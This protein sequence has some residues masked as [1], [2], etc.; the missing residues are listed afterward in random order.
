MADDRIFYFNLNDAG[1]SANVR[2][3]HKSVSTIE[4]TMLHTV[5]VGDKKKAV[6]CNGEGCKICSEK[7]DT[8]YKRVFIHLFDYT[9]NTEKVWSRTDKI[10][11]QLE[12][13]ENN[14]GDLSDCVLNIKRIQKEFPKYE[15]STLNP[16]QFEQ[17]DASLIDKSIAYRFYMTRSNDDI[18]K[19]Y[20]TGEFPPKIKQDYTPK[21][22]YKPAAEAPAPVATP[23]PK[24]TVAPTMTSTTDIM[25][26]NSAFTSFDVD[27]SD[28][29][30]NPFS[31]TPRKV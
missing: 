21:S 29:F 1:D 7:G 26:D 22:D 31:V 4:S 14:W 10:I 18:S 27:D 5:R 30:A 12:E 25:S 9:D 16:K 3:L 24:T 23:T 8:P 17:V 19:F 13:I 2:I 15:V 20:E 28:P 11:P 6:K